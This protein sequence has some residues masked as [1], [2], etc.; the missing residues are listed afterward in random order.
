MSSIRLI[1]LLFTS[2]VSFLFAQAQKPS[3]LHL[4]YEEN[5]S[6]TYDEVISMYRLLDDKYKEAKLYESGQTDGGQPLHTFVISKNREFDVSKLKKQGKTV[7][8]INNGIH[9][10]EPEGIDASLLFAEEILG[11]KDKPG[12][13]P[14]NT[15]VVIIP[16]YNIGGALNRSAWNRS[17]QTTP[18]ET[19]FRGNSANLD[20]NRDFTK[21]DSEEARSFTRIFQSWNPDVFLDTHTTNGSDHQHSITLIP[22]QADLFPAAMEKVI[23]GTLLPSLFSEMKKGKYELIPYVDWFYNDVRG[24]IKAGQ[25]SPRYSSGYAARF[26]CYGMMTENLIYKPFTDRVKSTYDFMRALLKFTSENN[27]LIRESREKGM[28]ET[29]KCTDFPIDFHIDT[30]QYQ[31]I[32]FSGY[33]MD[34]QQ[35]SQVTGI[36][37][38]GYDHN[39][40]FRDTIRWYNRY[41]VTGTLKVPEFYVVPQAWREVIFR[42]ELNKVEYVVL[43]K[44]TIIELQVDYLEDVAGAARPYNG[45]FYHEQFTTH[46]E[47]QKIRYFAGDWLIPVRQERMAY[48]IEMLE[49]KAKDSFFR[50]NFFDSVLDQR[51]YFSPYGFEENAL[52]TLQEFPEIKKQ[53]EIKKTTDPEFARNHAAQMAFIYNNSPWLE[54]SWKRYPVGRIFRNL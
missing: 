14:D 23:T 40:P 29:M 50:W 3:L 19:G 1:I 10:G 26:H 36:R 34:P 5:Y 32:P 20:L 22:P 15:V 4:R 33:E 42:L 48:I 51:E 35:L 37:R 9:P 53:I 7:L 16:V 52:R 41:K 2:T 38:P 27:S 46:S 18:Y 44:D 25:E 31:R 21:C 8:L 47:I 13:F 54:K 12:S 6:P 49:P 24:G 28:A 39:R 43:Q 17:G 45:H 30:T 11:N